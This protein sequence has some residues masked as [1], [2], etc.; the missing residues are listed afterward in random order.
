[1]RTSSAIEM[2]LIILLRT[3]LAQSTSQLQGQLFILDKTHIS[4]AA[5]FKIGPL[6]INLLLGA[7]DDLLDLLVLDMGL[8]QTPTA[9][10]FGVA[11]DAGG[12]FDDIVGGCDAFDGVEDEVIFCDGD[13]ARDGFSGD[14]FAAGDFDGEGG[15]VY[16]P[17]LDAD[18]SFGHFG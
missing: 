2:D 5:H 18:V 13:S 4:I 9:D 16:H 7:V 11:E 17:R 1:M 15:F 3:Q 10:G 6:L 12:A 14:G 8:D